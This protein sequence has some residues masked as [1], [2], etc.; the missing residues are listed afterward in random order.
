M[1]DTHVIEKC[2]I[3]L[4]LRIINRGTTMNIK[5]L[6]ALIAVAEAGSITRAAD[7]IF[8][9]QP[10]LSQRLSALE[11]ELGVK[12]YVRSRQGV[13]LTDVGQKLYAHAKHIV[14][15]SEEALSDI[16]SEEDLP[17]GHVNI[18][19]QASL[20]KFLGPRIIE[21]VRE[22]YPNIALSFLS[23]QS[24]N[25]YKSLADS[26]FELGIVHKDIYVCN[27]SSVLHCE[28]L[29]STSTLQY[30]DLFKEEI[31]YCKPKAANGNQN[32]L[33]EPTPID[34]LIDANLI[35][36]PLS[37]AI[38]RNIKWILDKHG[39]VQKPIAYT[40]S[41]DTIVDLVSRGMATSF[42]P[43]HVIHSIDSQAALSYGRIGEYQLLRSIILCCSP[44]SDMHTSTCVVRDLIVDHAA[45]YVETNR[46]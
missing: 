21:T 23:G 30:F 27:E 6:K 32:H 39:V 9:A 18:G 22:K 8:I 41:T 3:E 10:A 43:E 14:K 29:F 26:T 37:H 5:H 15:F 31:F 19:C 33:N 36:P 45:E 20:A 24:E 25:L 16:K 38:T 2:R 46:E 17:S 13:Q 35:L 42:L 40:N 12:L 4:F 34:D 44:H 7:Q 28:E 1:L 11:D